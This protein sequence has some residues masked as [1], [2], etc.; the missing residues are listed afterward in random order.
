MFPLFSKPGPIFQGAIRFKT[1]DWYLII[2]AVLISGAG[3]LTMNSFAGENT[4]FER[5][6]IWIAIS[7]TLF[8]ALSFVDFR[9]LRRT[10]IVVIIFSVSVTLLSILLLKGEAIKGAR[11]WFDFGV[12]SFQPVDL[13]K[14][15]LILLLAK[16]FSRRHIEIAHIRHIIVSGLYAGMIF[17]LVL[18]Q[19]DFG[20]A[21]II[22]LVWLGMVLISGISKKHLSLV[23]FGGAVAVVILWFFVFEDYQKQ[24]IVTFI[25]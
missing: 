21:I 17:F 6:L 20:S 15:S 16:Y 2:A 3:L 7:I 4:F 25:N 18:L 8:L 9:F 13:A 11:S 1:I 23:L 19:P 14:L 24:R 12:L 22:L 5:Q 10:D